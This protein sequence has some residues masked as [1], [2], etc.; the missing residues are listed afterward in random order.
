MVNM[1]NFVIWIQ[2]GQIQKKINHLE[3]N[4]VDVDSLKEDKK[5]FITITNQP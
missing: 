4:K 1:Q 2:T 3:K 5:E